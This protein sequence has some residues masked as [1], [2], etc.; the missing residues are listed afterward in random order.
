[1]T[2]TSDPFADAVAIAFPANAL[3]VGGT[4]GLIITC[5]NLLPIGR[6][7]GGVLARASLGNLAGPVGFLALLIL[8]GGSW[9]GG[10]AGSLYLAFGISTVVFNNSLD[11]PPREDITDVGASTKVLGAALVVVGI[12]L[13][14]PGYILPNY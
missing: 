1:M 11:L 3:L 2:D 12:L 7:D 9:D 5:L 4:C 14:I 6:L 13:S 8:V 10:D